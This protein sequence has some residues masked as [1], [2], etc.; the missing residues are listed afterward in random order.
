[1]RVVDPDDRRIRRQALTVAVAV[2]VFGLS[3]G[4]LA[5]DTGLSV[6][7]ASALSLLVFAG[8]SQLAAVSIAGDGSEWAGVTS[9]LL[10]NL[11]LLAFGLLAA[12]IVAGSWWRRAT[13]AH[14]VVDETVAL[15]VAEREPARRRQMFWLCAVLLYVSWNAVTLAGVVVGDALGD[16]RTIGL[17]A[18]F[19]AVFAA[20]LAPRLREPAARRSACAGAAIALLLVPLAPPGV[21]VVAAAAGVLAGGRSR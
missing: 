4:V 16:P 13:G 14:L 1:M 12:P 18:A 3:F 9:G 11:R 10:L 2:S 8:G 7:K 5:A 20:L 21:P 6:A 15:A 17:D 19:P